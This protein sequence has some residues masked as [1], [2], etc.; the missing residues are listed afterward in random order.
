MIRL[1]PFSLQDDIRLP[2]VDW[3]TLEVNYLGELSKLYWWKQPSLWLLLSLVNLNVKRFVELKQRSCSE[4]TFL[5]EFRPTKKL[6][7]G[8]LWCRVDECTNHFLFVVPPRSFQCVWG[9]ALMCL[10]L[11]F[12]VSRVLETWMKSL[13]LHQ[14]LLIQSPLHH[15][16]VARWDACWLRLWLQAGV[17]RRLAEIEKLLSTTALC[18]ILCG[19]SIKVLRLAFH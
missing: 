8:E 19:H 7:C 17:I 18:I 1:L 12:A 14:L 9:I 6:I 2:V 10:Q 15:L 11:R 4:F 13:L 16:V 3:K 5:L